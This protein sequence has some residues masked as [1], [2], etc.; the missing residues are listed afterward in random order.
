[1]YDDDDDASLK[2]KQVV[3]HVLLNW[4]LLSPIRHQTMK[5]FEHNSIRLPVYE[6]SNK[7]VHTM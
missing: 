3:V 2:V 5:V 6:Y 7:T 4:N 1:M